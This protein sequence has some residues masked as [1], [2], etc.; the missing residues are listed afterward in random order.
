MID[1]NSISE[2]SP[3]T[4][5]HFYP[6]SERLTL[7]SLVGVQIVES[8]FKKTITVDVAIYTLFALY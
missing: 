4:Q 3:D 1:Y 2:L 7:W 6:S 5:W 8:Y